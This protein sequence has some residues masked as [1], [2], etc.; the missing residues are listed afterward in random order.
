MVVEPGF[1]KGDDARVLRE[2]PQFI[3]E[4]VLRLGSRIG[5]HADHRVDLGIFLR[6]RHGPAAA[7]DAGADGDDAGHARRLGPRQHGVEIRGEIGEVEMRVGVDQ[8]P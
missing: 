7:F 6:E 5:M 3:D 1:A 8:H 4:V 2:D